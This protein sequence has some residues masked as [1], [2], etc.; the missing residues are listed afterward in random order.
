MG[1]GAVV[2]DVEMPLKAVM[3]RPVAVSEDARV[4]GGRR[5]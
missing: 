4:G 1:S 2:E 3:R 5:W